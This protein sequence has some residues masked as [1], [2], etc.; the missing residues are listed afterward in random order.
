MG[1]GFLCGGDENV[2]ILFIEMFA[3]PCG[4]IKNLNCTL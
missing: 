2:L 3:Q 4:Y 1:A